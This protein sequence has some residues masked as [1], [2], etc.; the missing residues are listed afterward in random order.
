MGE[1]G[2]E[3]KIEIV[4]HS[5]E[6]REGGESPFD[7]AVCSIVQKK[8][9]KLAC[10][11]L[12]VTYLRD[13]IAKKASSWKIIT[14]LE[15]WMRAADKPKDV[16]SFLEKNTNH[17]RHVPGLHAKVVM[18]RHQALVGSANLTRGGLAKREEVSILIENKACLQKL[19]DWFDFLWRES[20]LPPMEEI[21]AYSQ[22]LPE[23]NRPRQSPKRLL[24]SINS[25]NARITSLL[26]SRKE[27]YLLGAE[28]KKVWDRLKKTIRQAPE[29]EWI[30]G[31]FELVKELIEFTGLSRDDPRLVL[32]MPKNGTLPVTV[33]QRYALKAFWKHRPVIGFMLDASYRPPK[34]IEANIVEWYYFKSTGVE[35]S[36][37]DLCFL[38]FKVSD[39]RKIPQDLKTRWRHLVTKAL[40]GGQKSPYKRHHVDM[41]YHIVM[42]KELREALLAEVFS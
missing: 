2:F 40:E 17:I 36:D 5:K 24:S 10:P 42:D 35:R 7:K 29:K 13:T 6:S 25:P 41:L 22:N 21:A 34:S 28:D 11:Y 20:S 1:D 32:S 37:G 12:S 38:D 33:G 19:H 4:C 31:Y 3:P 8:N 26:T 39:M 23:T 27:K 9:V 14:D 30:D 18:N 16:R 15:E